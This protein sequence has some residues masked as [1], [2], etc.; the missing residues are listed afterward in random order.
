MISM[1]EMAKFVKHHVLQNLWRH[2]GQ[3]PVEV[4]VTPWTTTS[5]A[6]PHSLDPDHA[7]IQDLKIHQSLDMTTHCGIQPR[8]DRDKKT[9]F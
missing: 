2:K 5:P 9:G 3:Y 1:P 7:G 4:D 6:G 8:P